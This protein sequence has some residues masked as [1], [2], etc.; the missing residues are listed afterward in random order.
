MSSKDFSEG[1]VCYKVTDVKMYETTGHNNQERQNFF[2]LA[3]ISLNKNCRTPTAV[4]LTS[5][6]PAFRICV[7]V[8]I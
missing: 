5:F 8:N 3:V 4:S 2:I 6:S 7:D 1:A